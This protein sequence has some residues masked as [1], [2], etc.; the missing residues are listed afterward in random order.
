MTHEI[1]TS[2]F[3]PRRVGRAR[4]ESRWWA[5]RTL[6]LLVPLLAVNAP[7]PLLA[8]PGD[9]T[10]V[11]GGPGQGAALSVAQ[12]PAA[13]VTS[14]PYVY[15]AD[16]GSLVVRRLDTRTGQEIVVA[17]NGLPGFSGDGGPA[18]NAQLNNPQGVAMDAAGNLFIAEVDNNRIRKVDTSGTITT[19]AGTGPVCTPWGPQC[20][21]GFGGDGGP[22]TKAQLSRPQR[23]TV[24]TAGNL[25]IADTGNKRVRKVDPAGTITTV[26][27]GLAQGSA[28]SIPQVPLSVAIS[29]YFVYVADGEIGGV[30]RIDTRTGNEIV[31]AGNGFSGFSGDGGPATNA[32]FN[33]GEALYGTPPG[34]VADS[35][36]NLFIADTLNYRIRKVDAAGIVTTVAGNGTPGFSGDGGPATDAELGNP[37]GVAVDAAGNLFIA[38]SMMARVRKVDPAG[39]ITTVAGNGSF[40]FSGDGGPATDAELSYPLGVAVDAAGNLFIADVWNQRIRK[41]DAAGTMRTVAGNCI[42]VSGECSGGFGGDGGA[43]TSAQLN[44]P[45]GVTVDAAGDLFIADGN[46]LRIRRVDTAGTI[47]TVAGGGSPV[48]GVGDGG[49]ATDAEVHP[50]GVAADAAG[51][52]FIA[53]V[54]NGRIRKVDVAGTITTI[55][56]YGYPGYG[57]G[58]LGDG[59][60]AT[61]AP[62]DGPSGVAVD[63]TGNLFIADSQR[64]RRVDSIGTITTL[65]GSG[66]PGFGGDGGPATDAQLNGP[67][68]VAVDVTGNL[69]IADSANQRIRSV[70]PAGTITT[71]A[72][73]GTSGFSG[74][75]G[76]AIGAQINGPIDV[77]ADASGNLFIADQHNNR[78]RKVD[79]A[80]TITTLA[81]NGGCCSFGGDGGPATGAQLSNPSRV[82][83]DASGNLFIVDSGN[84]RIRKVDPAGTITTFV[85]SLTSVWLTPSGVAVDA[86]GNLFIAD[87]YDNR[88][89]KVDTTGTIT[90]VAGNGSV[91]SSG[92]GGPAT[93]AQ[94]SGPSGVAIDAAGNLLIADSGNNR[95]RRVD[96]AG[97]ITTVAGNGIAGF[98]GDGGLATSAQLDNPSGVAVDLAGD[99]FIADLWN[100]RI[101]K[102]DTTGTITTVAGTGSVGFGGDNGLAISAQLSGPSGVAIDAA[103]NLFIVDS[104]NNRI[105]K[106]DATGTITTVAGN[107]TTGFSGD[108]G[109]ATSAQL[110]GPSGIAVD[111]AGNLFIVDSGNS[112][113]RKVEAAGAAT[114]GP[115]Q[116]TIDDYPKI[117]GSTSTLPLAR[118][119]ACELLGLNFEWVP[120]IG[121]EGAAEIVAVPKTV[122][123]GQLADAVNQKIVHNQTHQAYLNLVDATADL[124]LVAN[125]PSADETA[126]AQTAGVTLKWDPVALDALVMLV[127]SSN[128]VA[129]LTKDQI[130]GIFMAQ[131]TSWN[132]V[133]GGAGQIDPYVRP[134]N[135][136]SQ[137]LFN[138][139]VMAG[140]TMPTWPPDQTPTMMGGLL[141]AVA[142]DSNSIGYSVY[143][144]V[145]YQR[146]T[147]GAKI[148]AVDGVMPTAETIGTRVY[149]F[150]APV[151][152]VIRENLDP[153]SLAYQ[154]R[155]WL[156][157]PDGQAVVA[158]SG[159]VQSG[160]PACIGDCH[161][162]GH[163]TVD[164]IL[165]IV[166]IALG[167]AEMSECE[168][169]DTDKDGEITVDEILVAVNNA[170]QGCSG[171]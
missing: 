127:N 20:T 45:L 42:P 89:H 80:G 43:A 39:T 154:M 111:V 10:T 71:V 131:I 144:Y 93:S 49:P 139:V 150:T 125:P 79:T 126:Y 2:A 11:A 37:L 151:L 17:G 23:V 36:G 47:S 25:F 73:N 55:A 145:T 96:L 1:G 163:V 41:V 6:W 165:T 102:V 108:G 138:A 61:S 31:V 77:A 112:R 44:Y 113:I 28:R 12:G 171:G 114:T 128:P 110:N 9:I 64:I 170:L 56:G 129:T 82:A 169:G 69:Y 161:D 149:P 87:S 117:D 140:L 118:V 14:G 90:T 97:T 92:D 137:Q 155:Q 27:G 106:V 119:I 5:V 78:V 157:S 88:I 24:D 141:D 19:I 95:I 107:G 134:I 29:G 4:P 63:A 38:D 109:L 153:N 152:V 86:S 160:P 32:Q 68:G 135:S 46:N 72:G 57:S 65:A 81:G 58:F 21:P 105:R 66:D 94:L 120:G 167:N 103:G 16:S 85:G 35:A 30:R 166:N 122:D 168:V 7:S 98:G 3:R 164:E 62:L 91:G 148:I 15:V 53:D 116:V 51:N 83:V 136:G 147:Q 130:R 59:G 48:D 84:R 75:G 162:D 121:A 159:Y 8:A 146:P 99:L 143:Y 54:W 133:G 115:P 124:I 74:D 18:T 13:V 158:K 34:V 123:Q 156:L 33:F 100:Q 52:V 26:A 50:F 142:F 101:R 76:R 60:P 70:D 132:A 40:G 104:G 67:S 22:A